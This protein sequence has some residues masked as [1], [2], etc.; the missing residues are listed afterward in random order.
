MDCSLLGSSVCEILQARSLSGL[1]FPPPGDF[2][3]I[4]GCSILQGLSVHVLNFDYRSWSFQS[5]SHIYVTL[6]KL[7]TLTK[8][9]FPYP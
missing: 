8:L 5:T 9:Q 7:L 1:P 4:D 6:Y 2:L 3:P